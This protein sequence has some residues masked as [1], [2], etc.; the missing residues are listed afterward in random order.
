MWVVKLGGSLQGSP[1]LPDWVELLAECGPGKVVIVPGGGVFADTVRSAQ[2]RWGLGDGAAHTMALLAMEQYA[3][4]LMSVEPRL[5]AAMTADELKAVL[6]R[7]RVPIWL[8]YFLVA[9]N[10]DIPADWRVTSDSLS[11][12][13]ATRMHAEALILIKAVPA[14]EI[15]TQFAE[16]SANGWLDEYFPSLVPGY[17]GAICWVSQGEVVQARAALERSDLPGRLLGS[18][19]ARALATAV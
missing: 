2:Q 3:H 9:G 11:L 1:L 19:S 15:H 8:P 12:W 7:N 17:A 5:C 10:A 14:P 16:L 18:P 6:A 13:L 4:L